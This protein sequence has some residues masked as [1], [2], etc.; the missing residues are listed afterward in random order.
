M[1]G[2]S[3]SHTN[4]APTLTIGEPVAG[5]ANIFAHTPDGMRSIRIWNVFAQLQDASAL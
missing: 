2:K 4:F 1:K 5:H 3:S